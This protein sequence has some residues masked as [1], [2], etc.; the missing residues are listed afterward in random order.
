MNYLN[1]PLIRICI[2]FVGGIL[3]GFFLKLPLA[4]LFGFFACIFLLFLFSYQFSKRL[5]SR[6]IYFGI[7]TFLL[8]FFTGILTTQLHLPKNQP[9]HYTHK[10][11]SENAAKTS[12]LTVTV[13]EELKPD[14]YNQ[15]FIASVKKLGEDLVHGKIL[16]SIQKDSLKAPFSVDDV[17]VI[18][19]A[20]E[21]IKPPLNPHQFNYKSFMENR[22]VLAQVFLKKEDFV[23]LN[24]KSKSLYGI[25]AAWRSNI[26]TKLRQNNLK[27]DEL[28][29]VQALLL[30]QKQDISQETYNNY[31][32]A[33][34]IHILAV[35]GLHV[36]IILFLLHWLFSPLERSKRGRFLK[37]ILIIVLLWLF[38]LL[39]GLSP[40][41]IRAV[42]MFSF[43]AIGLQLKRRTSVLN[44]L[45]LSMMLLLL[46][47]PQFIF[48]V[49]FQLSY[50]AVF[51]IVLLQ[52]PLYGM[53][54]P[55]YRLI[56]YFWGLLTVTIAAQAGVLPLSLFY[57]HQFPGLFFISNLVILPFMGFI[58]AYG[59][60]VIFLSLIGFLP[61]FIVDFYGIAIQLLNDFVG[62]MALQERFLFRDIHFSGI[63]ALALYALIMILFLLLKKI[64]YR[65]IMLALTGIIFLQLV[66]YFEKHEASSEE[67]VVFH[68]SRSSMVGLKDAQ[69]LTL[70]TNFFEEAKEPTLLKNYSVGE[71]IST[72]EIKEMQNFYKAGSKLLMVIDSAGIYKTDIPNPELLL[73]T[74][75][76]KIN[77]DRV[78][79]ELDPE[80]I[81]ADGSNYKYYVERWQETCKKR[82]IPFHY[83]ATDGT[84]KIAF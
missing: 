5:F 1:T 48:E 78:L 31:A 16:I 49:G 75:S 9:K 79:H 67:I 74:N 47:R 65:R 4:L 76:P 83:T 24:L 27:G 73:L 7:A 84:F 17:L 45:F 19:A 14:L 34:V 54:N 59:I 39:A 68:K 60:V 43:V 82:S 80:I 57:F 46:V 37:T 32:A 22:G 3:A 33:G 23:K 70:A 10:I 63:Q 52:P 62:F 30:G 53:W 61:A 40:S 56:K 36:G 55:K 71:N 81:I 6:Q 38:A 35:S 26:T 8:F 50:L 44:T 66:Y 21:P 51:A 58:L 28:G 15:K 72:I 20:V 2:F 29:V 41:V 64:S 77:L 18:H 25:T 13:T 69:K 42:T 11:S 12:F